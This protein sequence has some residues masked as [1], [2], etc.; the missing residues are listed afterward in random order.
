MPSAQLTLTNLIGGEELAGRALEH[1]EEAV[2]VRM[3]GD[4]ARRAAVDG[5]VGQHQLVHAVIVERIAR[6]HLEMTMRS[7]RSAAGTRRW[8]WNRDC[9]PGD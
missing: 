1:I 6:R 3:H 2:A 4:L 8:C 9:R 5:E 7:C